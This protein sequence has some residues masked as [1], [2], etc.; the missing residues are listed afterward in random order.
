MKL[1]SKD[2][3]VVVGQRGEGKTYWVNEHIVK[4]AKRVAIWSPYRRDYQGCEA[5]DLA[6]FMSMEE[7]L[8][9][10]EEFKIVVTVRYRTIADI[11]AD[12]GDFS[13]SV[14]GIC[15]ASKSMMVA[16][17]DEAGILQIPVPGDVLPYVWLDTMATQSR[18]WGESLEEEK[19]EKKK[20]G[21]AAL[22]IV[23]QRAKQI[24]PNTRSQA[25][26]AVSFFQ[27]EK[28]DVAALVSSYG[29]TFEKV[30]RLGEYE[31]IYWSRKSSRERGVQE[32]QKQ[33]G[34]NK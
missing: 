14:R 12:F 28:E 10:R 13:E 2:I 31:Y 17:V 11:A 7:D 21:G 4:Q 23:A 33:K 3:V 19:G 18:H 8:G 24:R 22:V 29:D 27:A 32:K 6:D 20:E 5:V 25:T 1:T 15:E 16:V 26:H 34:E 30:K 9:N